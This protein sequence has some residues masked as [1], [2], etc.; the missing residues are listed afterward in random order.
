M[1]VTVADHKNGVRDSLYMNATG[2]QKRYEIV[3]MR[4]MILNILAII[5]ELIS[6]IYDLKSSK[7]IIATNFVPNHVYNLVKKSRN[8]NY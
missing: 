4:R 6:L 7:I 3:S 5:N 2:R 1:I 8:K